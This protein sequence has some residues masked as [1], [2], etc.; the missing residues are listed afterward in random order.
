MI[1]SEFEQPQSRIDRLISQVRTQRF[2]RATTDS[3]YDSDQPYHA[4]RRSRRDA[5]WVHWIHS[6]APWSAMVTYTFKPISS[7]GFKVT[8]KTVIEA[9]NRILRLVNCE[10]FG[11]RRTNRGFTIAHAVL[12]D[13]GKFSEHLHAHMLIATPEGISLQ[14]IYAIFEKAA[15]RTHLVNSQRSYQHYYSSEGTGY[16]ID[17]GTDRMVVP[18]LR[19]AKHHG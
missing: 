13:K 3:R 17:H 6:F 19:R 4:R 8:E 10:L 15:Q 11:K 2:E 9:I 1:S 5:A 16:L 18:L 14:Q 12:V 7:R